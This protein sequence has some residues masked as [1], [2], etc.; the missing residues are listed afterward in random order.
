MIIHSVSNSAA[1]RR[2]GLNEDV[3]WCNRFVPPA[4]RLGRATF[5]AGGC[6]QRAKCGI[7]SASVED[8]CVVFGEQS[9]HPAL[10]KMRELFAKKKLQRHVCVASSC[11]F[12]AAHC[13]V[14]VQVAGQ[15]EILNVS[16]EDLVSYLSND[17]LNTKAEELVYEMVIKWI[18]QD[19]SSRAQVIKPPP[20][21]RQRRQQW[22]PAGALSLCPAADVT[23]RNNNADTH[24]RVRL[25]TGTCNKNLVTAEG[26]GGGGLQT[27]GEALA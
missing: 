3:I 6:E 25:Q 22:E 8:R 24:T 26:G 10:N 16:K 11:V 9:N 1:E 20:G 18:K 15:E 23:E 27:H 17:S 13:S 2:C 12:S 19:S 14:C 4:C 7:F 5:L 21:R